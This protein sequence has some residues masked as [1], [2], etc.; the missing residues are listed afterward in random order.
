MKSNQVPDYDT[1]DETGNT[2]IN[3]VS[4][5]EHIATYFENL[6]QAREANPLYK[7]SSDQITEQV[8]TWSKQ[9]SHN[10]NTGNITIKEIKKSNKE[11]KKWKKHGT[12]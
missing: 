11:T 7:A 2:L 5:K 6:Y 8:K 10:T 1:I 4:S 9:Q 12:R 3:P